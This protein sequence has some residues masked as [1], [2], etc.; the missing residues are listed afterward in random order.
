MVT[1]PRR[2]AACRE[3]LRM[4]S[5]VRRPRGRVNPPAGRWWQ[6]H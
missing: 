4:G 1:S 6:L 2:T 5:A 3:R